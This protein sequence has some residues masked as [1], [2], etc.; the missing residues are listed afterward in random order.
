MKAF[1]C[2]SC[3]KYYDN[4]PSKVVRVI[5]GTPGNGDNFYPIGG[6]MEPDICEECQIK[7]A[8]MFPMIKIRDKVTKE[9]L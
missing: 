2:D 5:F 9:E 4:Q 8:K 3:G 6:S 1:R 7:I